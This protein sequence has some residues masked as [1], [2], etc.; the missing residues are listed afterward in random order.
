MSTSMRKL[1]FCLI[2]LLAGLAAWP[3]TEIMLYYQPSFPSYLMFTVSLGMVFGAFMGG[4]LGS[5][6]GITLSVRS[7]IIPGILTGFIVGI[8]GGA[9]G[10]LVGQAALWMVGE[11]FFHSNQALHLYGIPLS[12]TIGWGSLGL[13]IG[14]IEGVRSR[15]WTKVKIGLLGGLVGG[16]LGG[17]ALEFTRLTFPDLTFG[18][19]IG[20]L[21]LGGL[22]GLFYALFEK[23]FSQGVLK[24]LNGK[25][26]GKE[27]LLIQNSTRLGSAH[28]ADIQLADYRHVAK[29]HARIE[30]QHHEAII[31]ALDPTHRVLV[32]EVNIKEAKL[33]F[34]DIIQ[35]G[36][37][38]FLFFYQ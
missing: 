29:N 2:G 4:F 25:L 11:T 24:I 35:I 26:K 13:F 36:S 23:Q 12:R 28:N 33:R 6:S 30:R 37:A 31:S 16:L 7:R 14:M 15:S 20:L 17:A 32:N 18:R 34:E 9:L 8:V 19:L 22:I 5:V 1:V 3:V 27:Y 21:L 10:F 38:K